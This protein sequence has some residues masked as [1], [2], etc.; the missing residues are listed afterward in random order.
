[1]IFE[2]KKGGHNSLKN[3]KDRNYNVCDGE[4]ISYHPQ[5]PPPPNQIVASNICL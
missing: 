3:S 5:T 2:L 4:Q 1:M